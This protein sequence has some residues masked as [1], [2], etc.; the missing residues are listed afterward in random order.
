MLNIA[1][2]HRRL[3][4][5][6]E[7][8]LIYSACL[9]ITNENGWFPFTSELHNNIGNVFLDMGDY[10]KARFNY[11]KSLEINLHIKNNIGVGLCKQNLGSLAIQM[12]DL[13]AAEKLL[14][15]SKIILEEQNSEH[16]LGTL[17]GLDKITELRKL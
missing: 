6:E 12:N 2:V 13:D 11:Q 16:L 10:E 9:K 4:M 15:E 5:H 8:L 17:K 7:A 3:K 14:T 1:I